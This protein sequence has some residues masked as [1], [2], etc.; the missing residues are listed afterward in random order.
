MS[1][2]PLISIITVVRDL[3]NEIS[4][5]IESVANQTYLNIEYII[6]DGCSTDNTLKTIN[7]YK[8]VA[9]QIISE[10]DTGIYDAMNKGLRIARGDFVTF[11]NGGDSYLSKSCLEEFS[12]QIDDR[13]KVY[14]GNAIIT[15]EEVSWLVPPSNDKQKNTRWLQKY[16]PCHQTVFYPKSFYQSVCYDESVGIGAD[17]D[18]TLKA[19][20][21]YSFD[22]INVNLVKF[23]L[24]GISNKFDTFN[25]AYNNLQSHMKIRKNHRVRYPIASDPV[26]FLMHWTKFLLFK[27]GGSKMQQKGMY[28]LKLISW[29]SFFDNRAV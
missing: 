22:H 2:H 4:K 25:Y 19:Y 3:E 9:H 27:L 18:Y 21:K 10:S 17:T 11:L 23:P 8:G 29:K 1:I 7:L 24:G 16:H 5:T 14:F 15:G 13:D 6:I 20:E 28:F 26:F 12:S